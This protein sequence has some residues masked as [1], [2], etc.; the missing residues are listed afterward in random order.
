MNREAR[1]RTRLV[2]RVGDAVIQGV[3]I[4]AALRWQHELLADQVEHVLLG[5]RIGQI[6]VQKVLTQALGSVLQLL[7]PEG[8]DRLDD[9]G[10]NGSKWHIH[11]RFSFHSDAKNQGRI[12]R[13][14]A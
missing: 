9:I 14:L 12:L 10:S 5:L 3:E 11:S 7:H 6:G 8:A 2:Q 13:K 4:L 1:L